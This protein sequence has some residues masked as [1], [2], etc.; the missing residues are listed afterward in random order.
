MAKHRKGRGGEKWREKRRNAEKNR[1]NGNK[2]EKIRGENEKTREKKSRSKQG[3]HACGPS[4]IPLNTGKHPI[5]RI[6]AL[7]VQVRSTALALELVLSTC[8]RIY[9]TVTQD[10]VV[11]HAIDALV[12]HRNQ[13]LVDPQVEQRGF[14]PAHVHQCVLR[15]ALLKHARFQIIT[16]RRET[17]PNNIS[18][19]LAPLTRRT[20]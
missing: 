5:S 11:R 2:M 9:T 6:Q 15:I 14:A 10:Q 3:G 1:E 16:R 17:I 18:I 8:D 20:H 19:T 4:P 7:C 13:S 12:T